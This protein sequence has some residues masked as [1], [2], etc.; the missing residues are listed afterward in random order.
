MNYL[1]HLYLAGDDRE[2]RLGNLLGEFV[3]G[4]DLSAWPAAIAEGIRQH[5]AIDRYTDSHPLVAA[6][7]ARLS[8]GFRR[9]G[10]IILDMA[11]DH[12]L[13]RHWPE[14]H[15]EA[16]PVF[17]ARV[18]A[19]LD[20]YPGPR[21][22]RMSLAMDH[23]RAHD[24]LVAYRDLAVLGRALAGI[25]TRLSRPN[26]LAQALPEVLKHYDA[27]ES[28]FLRFFPELVSAQGRN[29]PRPFEQSQSSPLFIPYST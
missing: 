4:P 25:G 3:R 2:R 5:R 22:G 28:D 7:R 19:E 15:P 13:A 20:G 1:A 21:P 10:G 26:P 6:S 27:L 8:P 12:F 18:Y 23:M 11:Y 9:Y 14:L 29:T 24:L 17:A 16:L